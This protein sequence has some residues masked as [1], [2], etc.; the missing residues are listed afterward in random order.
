MDFAP[1]MNIINYIIG[2]K[3]CKYI[4]SFGVILCPIARNHEKSENKRVAAFAKCEM[5]LLPMMEAK[6]RKVLRAGC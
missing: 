2:G 6:Y 3:K 1:I 4:H 5:L